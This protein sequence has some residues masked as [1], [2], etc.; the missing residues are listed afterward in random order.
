MIKNS[1][2]F[3][4]KAAALSAV[5]L[6]AAFTAQAQ[7]KLYLSDVYT[8]EDLNSDIFG[9]PMRIDHVSGSKYVAKYFNQKADNQVYILGTKTDFSEVYGGEDGDLSMG[10]AL[11]EV[12]AII[13]PEANKYYQ[14]D[15]D[16][17]DMTYSVKT[18]EV[19]DYMD[20]VFY[21]L[22]SMNHNVWFAWVQKGPEDWIPADDAWLREF[23]FGYT[24]TEYLIN[25]NNE[26]VDWD[27]NVVV[28]D[29]EAGI[30]ERVKAIKQ[31]P[32]GEDV[33]AQELRWCEP[34]T[35]AAVNK[36]LYTWTTPKHFVAKQ[37]LNFI[38]HNWHEAGWW[39]FVTWRVDDEQECDIFYYYGN[40]VKQSYLDY[41]WGP[42][43]VKVEEFSDND[44]KKKELIYGGG[45]DCWCKPTVQTTGNY[46]LQ[47]DTHLGRAKLVPEGSIVPPTPGGISSAVTDDE[48]AP[49][50]YFNLQGMQV[51]NPE[52]GVFIR[53]QGKTATKVLF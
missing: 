2:R 35:Q 41:A 37:K 10:S 13:L 14:I 42:G 48:N 32:I 11:D 27:G 52:N 21:D 25:D 53:R 44:D 23:Y 47:F 31:N 51:K 20:P 50:E 40:I 17:D 18:Y 4:L 45:G 19:A 29:K 12:P 5:V 7:Q 39:N 36:H 33:E 43:T 22:N 15:L 6:G 8:V 34:W 30:D 9:V 1:T 38:I 26:Y 3:L 49:V 24:G 28:Y 16:I 46:V